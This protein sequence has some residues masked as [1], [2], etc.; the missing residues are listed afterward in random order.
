MFATFRIHYMQYFIMNFAISTAMV[1]FPFISNMQYYVYA[2]L[3]YELCYF[4]C[5]VPLFSSV[6]FGI[7]TLT[8]AFVSSP[9]LWA[10]IGKLPF[11]SYV[12]FFYMRIMPSGKWL[13]SSDL[14]IVI[15]WCKVHRGSIKIRF[16]NTVGTKWYQNYPSL[17]ALTPRD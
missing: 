9:H 7:M 15:C 5:N 4:N 13:Q 11:A 16:E 8:M 10:W 3:Y 12:N 2:V 14:M 17:R 1:F 6:P